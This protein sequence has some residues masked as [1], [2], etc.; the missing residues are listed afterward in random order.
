MWYSFV[1]TKIEIEIEITMSRKKKFVIIYINFVKTEMASPMVEHISILSTNKSCLMWNYEAAWQMEN[2]WLFNKLRA[3]FELL[4]FE[5]FSQYYDDSWNIKMFL[6]I[7]LWSQWCGMSCTR[8]DETMTSVVIFILGS[9][10]NNM[11]LF[12]VWNE[13]AISQKALRNDC[14]H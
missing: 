9:N 6:R 8:F 3:V 12:C 2:I 11:Y 13:A 10:E 1:D 4:F 14:K 7:F 5:S